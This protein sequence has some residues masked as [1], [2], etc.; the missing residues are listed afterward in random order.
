MNCR[1]NRLEDLNTN[2]QKQLDVSK[3]KVTS[4]THQLTEVQ[5]KGRKSEVLTRKQKISQN[6]GERSQRRTD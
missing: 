6:Y 4:L 1:L 2:F 5:D 3:E